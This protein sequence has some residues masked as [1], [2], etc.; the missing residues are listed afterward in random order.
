MF[1]VQLQVICAS[2]ILICYIS[3]S[4]LVSIKSEDTIVG[5]STH[6]PRYRITSKYYRAV[7][8]KSFIDFI[9][10]CISFVVQTE[11]KKYLTRVCGNY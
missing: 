10:I 4:E 8:G 9:L 5:L 6:N 11:I 3:Y 7:R 2:N 1:I